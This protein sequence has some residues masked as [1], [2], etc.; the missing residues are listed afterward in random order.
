MLHNCESIAHQ[1]YVEKRKQLLNFDNYLAC[2][3]VY[4]FLFV[5]C[6]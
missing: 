5:L 2:D 6:A 4:W 1:N 3:F